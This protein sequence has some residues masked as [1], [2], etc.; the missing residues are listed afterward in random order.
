MTADPATHR[1]Y[2]AHQTRVEFIETN[3]GKAIGAV[4]GL[5][6]CHG[7]VTLPDGKTGYVSGGG[8]NNVVVFDPNN[9]ATLMTIPAG[10]NPDGIIYERS[11][12][13][14]WAFNGASKN[15]TVIDVASRKAVG[16]VALERRGA[17]ERGRCRPHR[18]PGAA[19]TSNDEGCADDGALSGGRKDLH[20]LG[21]AWSGAA[22]DRCDS[23]PTSFDFN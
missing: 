11:T 18:L 15:A 9:F 20:R 13:T 14:L 16:T 6:R 5:T 12:N 4:Q 8:A 17:I 22:S 7:V 21:E 19:D 1:L 10:T 3:T 23:T 2:I